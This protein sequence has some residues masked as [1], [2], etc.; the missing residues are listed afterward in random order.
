[1]T[2]FLP[3]IYSANNLITLPVVIFFVGILLFIKKGYF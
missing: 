2:G 3:Q 1:M